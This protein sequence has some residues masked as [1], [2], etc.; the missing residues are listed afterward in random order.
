MFLTRLYRH[1]DLG[2]LI[3]RIGVGLD[4]FF[5][6]GWGKLVG[7]PDSWTLY[8]GS[9]ERFGIHFMPTFWG[10][11]AAFSET[12]GGL[13]FAAGFLFVPVCFLLASTMLV[14]FT[15]DVARRGLGGGSHAGKALVLFASMGLIGPGKYSL[16]AW[17]AGRWS[18][19]PKDGGGVV[20]T[21]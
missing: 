10:F 15:G 8:G 16:D 18:Q 2:L 17:L 4:F 11:M 19:T 20:P 6:H 5:L 1:R 3:L 13:F 7:G 14:A 9:M 21:P 12:I